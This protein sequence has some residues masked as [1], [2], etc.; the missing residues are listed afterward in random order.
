MQKPISIL[1]SKLYTVDTNATHIQVPQGSS[2]YQDQHIRKRAYLLHYYV[3]I[4][5][6]FRICAIHYVIQESKAFK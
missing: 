6:H 5:M 4:Q 3:I 2:E 1:V